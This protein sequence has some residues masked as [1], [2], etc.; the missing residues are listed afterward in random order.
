MGKRSREAVEKD[1][2]AV[3]FVPFF[4]AI[5]EDMVSGVKEWREVYRFRPKKTGT[6]K[7]YNVKIVI[8]QSLYDLKRRIVRGSC[9]CDYYRYNKVKCKHVHKAI[10]LLREYVDFE[11]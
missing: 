11:E 7:W 2:E 6:K 10:R 1:I 4:Y 5:E 8:D 3:E 9:T